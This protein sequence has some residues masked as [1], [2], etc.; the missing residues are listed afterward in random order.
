MRLVYSCAAHCVQLCQ[1]LAQKV[2]ILATQCYGWTRL[3]SVGRAHPGVLSR[4]SGGNLTA[5]R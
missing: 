1:K 2:R 3:C 4:S 5:A